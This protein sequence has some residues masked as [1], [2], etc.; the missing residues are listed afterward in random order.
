MRRETLDLPFLEREE[1]L[2]LLVSRRKL[3]R[4]D[5]SDASVRGLLDSATGKRFLIQEGE[6]FPAEE[7]A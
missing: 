5:D 7:V 1:F 2:A 6:L 3:V 4:A